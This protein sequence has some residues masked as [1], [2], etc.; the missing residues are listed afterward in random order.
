MIR[1]TIDLTAAQIGGNVTGTLD[2]TRCNIGVY[3]G[4]A[5][6]GSVSGASYFGVVVNGASVNVT[7]SLVHDI[8]NV[9]L[10]GSEH[11]SAIVYLDG[12]SGTVSD[13]GHA[14]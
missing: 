13:H 6:S 10:D 12:A 2:L 8:G 9:P 7:T 3:Y 5:T 4:P 11:G 14:L 1:D